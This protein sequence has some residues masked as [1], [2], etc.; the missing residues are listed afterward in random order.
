MYN[1]EAFTKK[2]NIVI[3]NSFLAAGKL[4]HTYVGSEHILLSLISEQSCSAAQAFRVCGITEADVRA[5][6]I[7]LVGIGEP[8]PVDDDC[9]TS[10]A[11]KILTSASSIAASCGS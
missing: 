9:M 7:E 10:C 3:E 8:C 5:K 6:I 2:A 1:I 4:G 11:H